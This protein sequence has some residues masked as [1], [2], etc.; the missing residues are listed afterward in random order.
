MPSPFCITDTRSI[1]QENFSRLLA[2]FTPFADH[3]HAFN[4]TLRSRLF[5]I[6][7]YLVVFSVLN[8][9][10]LEAPDPDA[11]PRAVDDVVVDDDVFVSAETDPWNVRA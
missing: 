3:R 7:V 10:F 4:R 8:T 9:V 11:G 5:A 1:A 2:S 6:H